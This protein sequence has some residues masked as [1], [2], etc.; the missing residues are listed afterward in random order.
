L[1]SKGWIEA[2]IAMKL[3]TGFIFSIGFG[4]IRFMNQLYFTGLTGNGTLKA[5]DK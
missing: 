2:E 5:V 3:F 1:I 4:R